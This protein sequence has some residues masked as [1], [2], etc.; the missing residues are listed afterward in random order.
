MSALKNFRKAIDKKQDKYNIGF[1]P[2]PDWID[3]GNMALNTIISG[4]PRK[5]WPVGRVSMLSGLQ[6]TGKSFLVANAVREAQKK[7]YFAVYLD[8]ENAIDD[9][10]MEGIGVDMSEDAFMPVSVFSVEEVTQFL[11]DL[12]K[13][14]EKDEK[15][16]L[17]IDS[18]SNLE[19]EG[20]MQKFDDGKIA[21]GQGLKEKLYKQLMRNI[22]TKIGHRDMICL[23]NSHMYVGGQDHY[24]NQ[25]LKPSCGSATLYLPSVGVELSKK[26][27]KEGKEQIGITINA[28]TYKSRYTTL[29]RKC[30]FPLPFS[31]GM[32][33]YD[34]LLPLLEEE[35]AVNRNGAW[36]NITNKK[37]G[38]EVKFQKKDME[39]Y[40]DQ[41]LHI[42]AELKGEVEEAPESDANE[43]MIEE[44]Q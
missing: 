26:D 12:F 34:G 33:P 28:K 14:T 43:D 13:N 9:G 36:Y 17:I 18:L 3:S 4:D 40:I 2:I 1:A 11:A 37:T 8:T 24:G 21:Y 6:G 42:Y 7:G 16:C 35:G 19:A 10:F 38:E 23:A 15:I 41:I 27:L 29:G 20:D 25:I 22:S 32:N 39:K 44:I 31:T 30:S 5:G